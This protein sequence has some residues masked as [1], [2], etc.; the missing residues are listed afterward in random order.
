MPELRSTQPVAFVRR[1]RDR[2]LA[3]ERNRALLDR[4]AG[5]LAALP[6]WVAVLYGVLL[7]VVFKATVE[8]VYANADIASGPM[9]GETYDGG[10]LTL[11]FLNWFEGLWL[12]QITKWMPLH[13]YLWQYGP[14]VL[15]MLGLAAVAWTAARATGRRWAGITFFA[16]PFCATAALMPW[17]FAI[18]G[19]ALAWLTVLLVGA[20]L[21][22][23]AWSAAGWP[24][25]CRSTSL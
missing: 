24:G 13:R 8:A 11:G 25:R 15:T 22:A 20:F 16:V 21:V 1:Q 3:S 18:S 23:A 4:A 14:W 10:V 2:I 19:H 5:W 17:Q 7:L 6:A 12:E 9:I